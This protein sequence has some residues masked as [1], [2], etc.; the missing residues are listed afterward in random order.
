MQPSLKGLKAYE[1]AY[2]KLLSQ[3]LLKG[4]ALPVEMMDT[5]K[6]KGSFGPKLT[7]TKSSFQLHV[8][9]GRDKPYTEDD[10]SG[11]AHDIFHLVTSSM[12]KQF[13]PHMNKGYDT[14][15]FNKKK[16]VDVYTAGIKAFT[17]KFGVN[18]ETIYH[19]TTGESLKNVGPKAMSD[20]QQNITQD[21]IQNHQ[22]RDYMVGLLFDGHMSTRE[23][24]DV[25]PE[26]LTKIRVFYFARGMARL[27]G[28]SKA[29]YEKQQKF[30]VD[31]KGTLDIE[32]AT[33]T[34]LPQYDAEEDAGN[35]VAF[36]TIFESSDILSR[37]VE[38]I[39]LSK[40]L[41]DEDQRTMVYSITTRLG[42][43]FTRDTTSDPLA[44][45]KTQ[46][47]KTYILSILSPLMKTYN[48]YINL[49]N[50]MTPTTP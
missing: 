13:A 3:G 26:L 40:P 12:A 43:N 41:T 11:D 1:M 37:L 9:D 42:T 5:G 10:F 23:L 17:A 8:N 6:G 50:K 30:V 21:L 15:K 18:P 46:E 38:A 39:R 33:N 31:D 25:S 45:A 32:Y 16:P 19:S 34:C 36:K 47:I 44:A 49:L 22:W 35:V 24:K 14:N 4:D 27:S 7:R 20:L 29:H 28:S 2:N 48:Y